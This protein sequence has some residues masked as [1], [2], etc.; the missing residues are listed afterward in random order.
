MIEKATT[1]RPSSVRIKDIFKPFANAFRTPAGR[2]G[3]PLV[4]LHVLLAVFGS[5]LAPYSPTDFSDATYVR[6]FTDA[7]EGTIPHILGTDLSLIHI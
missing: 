2:I 6:P 5:Y 7:A 3:L 4:I 1:T